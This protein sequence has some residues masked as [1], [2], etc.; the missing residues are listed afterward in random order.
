[1][2]IRCLHDWNVSLEEAADIQRTLKGMLSFEFPAKKVSIVAGVDVSFPQK[3]LGLCVI[4]VMDDTLKVIESVYHTQEVHIPYVSGFLSFREGPIFIE[5]VKKLKIVPDLFF[6]DGQGI[7]HPRGLGIAAHMGLLLEKPSLGVA[8]SH[9]F[10]SYNEPGR[11]KGD[12]SYMYN[13][14][15]EII[16]TVLRTKKNTKPVFVSPGHMMDVDTAMSLTLKYTGKYRLP[17]P[18]RQAHILTQRLRKNHLLR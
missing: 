18:T 8:K 3:N 12:F 11:N 16:G 5:T 10:G 7:A 6:F 9:L 4:V 14:T 17:E 13:K 15:G 1:M 2:K